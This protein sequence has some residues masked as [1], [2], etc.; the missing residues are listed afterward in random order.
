MSGILAGQR[1]DREL[2]EEFVAA[3]ARAAP[4]QIA[5]DRQYEVGFRG[6]DGTMHL[7]AKLI[8]DGEPP[9]Q[10]AVELMR[11]GYPRDMRNAVWLL[12]EYARLQGQEE[13]IPA[14]VADRLS[15]GA[16]ELLRA[17]GI[18]FYD[19]SGSLFFKRGDVTIDIE[20]HTR[21]TAERARPGS[22]FY[23][24]REQVVHA[25]LA[26]GPNPFTGSEIAEAAKT[27]VYT[28]SQTLTVLERQGYV[29]GKGAGRS[30]QRRLT[31]PGQLLDAWAK[32]WVSTPE[33]TSSWF[34]L[35]RTPK[36]LATSLA[37]KLLQHGSDWAFTGAEA[38]NYIAPLLTSVDRVDV[39][40]PRGH[41]YKLA[42]AVGLQQAES[43]AN[44]KLIERDGASELFR[45][46]VPEFDIPV[47]SPFIVYL[48]L[49]KD[50]RGR[51]KELAQH[52][53]QTVL[54]I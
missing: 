39:I 9:A 33:F 44:V 29:S 40:V 51:N 18:A 22:E 54:K 17:R 38:G 24:A 49:L 21:P 47:A 41:A 32:A 25:L 12:Q 42:N 2:L 23:G 48:D 27:S 26:R 52:L 28:V 7:D 46:K 3:L 35:A 10:I 19:R 53:R 20:R 6:F 1:Q 4:V 31:D 34:L 50:D 30:A 11:S 15:S 8:V 36:L 43:G 37:S 45:N 5:P 16:R 13:I 14:V